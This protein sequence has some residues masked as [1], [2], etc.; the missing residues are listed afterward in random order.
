MFTATHPRGS[1]DTPFLGRDAGRRALVIFLCVAV[2]LHAPLVPTRLFDWLRVMLHAG[3]MEMVDQ[4]GETIVPIDFDLVPDA[5]AAPAPPPEPAAPPPALA[6]P[7][8]AP[9]TTGGDLPKP[10]DKPAPEPPD[11]GAPVASADPDAGAPKK[12]SVKDPLAA[13]GAVGKLASTD[14]NVQVLIASDRIR[15]HPLGAAFGKLLTTIPEWKSFFE[16]TDLDPIRDVDH[17]LI[18]GP[19]FRDSSKVVAVMD[20]NVPEPRVKQAIDVIVQRSDPAGSWLEDSPVPAATARADGGDRIFAMVPGKRLLVVMPADA[21]EQL[22]KLK[23][24]GNFNKSSAV[25]IAVAMVTPGRAFK[26]LPVKVPES[27]KWLR[28]AVIPQ[29]DGGADVTLELMDESGASASEHM[30]EMTRTIEAVRTLSIPLLGTVELFGAVDASTEDALIRL[31][32]KVTESQLRRIMTHVE[33]ELVRIG[34][35]RSERQ[36]KQGANKVAPSQ[37]A[38]T[39]PEA[40][41]PATNT[42]AP[43]ANN[44]DA[45]PVPKPPGAP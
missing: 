39:A 9:T 12:P 20:Y 16:G 7:P 31:R 11:A 25:G 35:R 26:G 44:E 36:R 38:D 5:P 21:K 19:Q 32:T 17:V 34:T 4:P 15:K 37:T 42:V 33:G 41:D 22:G 23:S 30:A 2:L 18:A 3:D 8:A 24:A 6:A 29:A 14:P 13:A 40:A 45:V 28:L 43:P 10:P 1:G 27:L